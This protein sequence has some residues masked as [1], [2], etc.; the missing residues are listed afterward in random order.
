MELFNE[1]KS[2]QFKPKM[3]K[4]ASPNIWL[5]IIGSNN[6]HIMQHNAQQQ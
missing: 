5:I 2:F 1:F 3:L 6:T 4:I